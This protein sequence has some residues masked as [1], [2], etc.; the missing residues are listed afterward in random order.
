M[1]VDLLFHSGGHPNPAKLGY[2]V[3]VSRTIHM[4]WDGRVSYNTVD[5][6]VVR[7]KGFYVYYLSD[8]ENCFS[9][10]CGE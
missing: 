4:Q 6:L 9:T 3:E 8:L 5:T 2:G 10:Y 1:F 7:C